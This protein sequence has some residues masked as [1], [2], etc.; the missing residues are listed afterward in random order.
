MINREENV[1]ITSNS[2][3]ERANYIND[4]NMEGNIERKNFVSKPGVRTSMASKY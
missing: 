3:R 4:N 2:F 1:T